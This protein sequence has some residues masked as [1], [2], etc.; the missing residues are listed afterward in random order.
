MFS[1]AAGMPLMLASTAAEAKAS[2]AAVH[3]RDAHVPYMQVLY[4]GWRKAFRDGVHGWFH[5]G[6]DGSLSL[7]SR[8]RQ[9]KPDGLLRS[10]CSA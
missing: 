8:R 5:D 6:N 4:R 7:P 10:V 2:K 3:Y 1:V 9:D